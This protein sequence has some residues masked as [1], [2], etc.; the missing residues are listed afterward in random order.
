MGQDSSMNLSQNDMD[1]R[2]YIDV[3]QLMHWPGMLTGIPRVMNE[4]SIRYAKEDDVCFVVWDKR[5]RLY[6]TVRLLPSNKTGRATFVD[7]DK[8]GIALTKSTV[9][10]LKKNRATRV[11]TKYIP[12]KRTAKKL[13]L[14]NSNNR[15]AEISP[16]D[17]LL[18]LWGEWA[19]IN[20]IDY[21][22]M[23]NNLGVKI[24]QV[25][26]DVLPL[27]TPQYSG[28]STDSMRIYNT[29]IMPICSLVLSIS[30]STKRDLIAW[31]KSSELKVPTIKVFRLG[32]NF[33]RI[34]PEKPS[35]I[36]IINDER[37][38]LCVGTIEARKNHTLL[39]YVYKLAHDRNI[40]LPKLVIVGRN[41]WRTDDFFKIATEDP[42]TQDSFIFL[43]S[44][45]DE[46]LAWLY[47]NSLFTVYPSFYE[48]WGLPIAES[49]FY[50]VPCISSNTSSMPEIAGDLI[51]YFSPVSTDE[52][53]TAICKLLKPNELKNSI[54]RIEKYRPT[55]WDDTYDQFDNYIKELSI[56]KTN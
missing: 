3:T 6:T 40:R 28:H 34:K 37:Y 56:E 20:F 50:G 53:L 43:T 23:L 41:G 51:D 30:E 42:R 36:S 48:G 19:S 9:G 16:G 14:S 12:G 32:D 38:I 35:N 46:E 54:K 18:I 24:I 13:L 31:M 7:D 11:F 10:L 17:R 45:S 27:I 55:S 1:S 21:V 22:L 15:V 26:Y 47:E 4:L 25:A 44:T 33:K 29:K 5:R 52:C 2:L 39:Y 8:G 49:I